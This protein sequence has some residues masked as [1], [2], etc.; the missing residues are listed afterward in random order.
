MRLVFA[1]GWYYPS[2]SFFDTRTSINLYIRVPAWYPPNNTS[3]NFQLAG[4][5]C[6]RG[7]AINTMSHLVNKVRFWINK[8]HSQLQLSRLPNTKIKFWHKVRIRYPRSW[9]G[10]GVSVGEIYVRR[11]WRGATCEVVESWWWWCHCPDILSLP[12]LASSI[13]YQSFFFVFFSLVRRQ[14]QFSQ[15]LAFGLTTLFSLSLSLSL[16]AVMGHP[17]HPTSQ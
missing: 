7:I 14:R 11:R 16:L 1:S 9:S 15:I 2:G 6:E 17:I 5:A 8:H 3:F 12:V 13:P 10:G 4:H